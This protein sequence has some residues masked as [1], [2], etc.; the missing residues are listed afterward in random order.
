MQTFL[1]LKKSNNKSLKYSITMQIIKIFKAFNKTKIITEFKLILSG[2]LRN[3]YFNI[4]FLSVLLSCIK[5]IPKDKGP[6]NN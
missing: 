4:C 1:I 6:K 5:Y 3:K 2:S